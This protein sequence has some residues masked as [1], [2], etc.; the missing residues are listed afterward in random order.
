[1]SQ[2]KIILLKSIYRDDSGFI[3]SCLDNSR[4]AYDHY[5]I[6]HQQLRKESFVKVM[7]QLCTAPA[8]EF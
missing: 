8:L 6:Y 2:N 1:M 3:E 7:N 5:V 4:T